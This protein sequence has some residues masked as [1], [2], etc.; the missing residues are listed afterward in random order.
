MK[1]GERQWQTTEMF[2]CVGYWAF[3]GRGGGLTDNGF[4]NLRGN[5]DSAT[6]ILPSA[7]DVSQ[8][9]PL[10]RLEPKDGDTTANRVCL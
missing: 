5:R 2:V 7:G 6:R 3:R 9:T 1:G 4:C 8:S 10:T